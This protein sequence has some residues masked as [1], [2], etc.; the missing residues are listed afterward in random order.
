MTNHPILHLWE[1]KLQLSGFNLT[2]FDSHY[3]YTTQKNRMEPSGF[4]FRD[5]PRHDQEKNRQRICRKRNIIQ[6]ITLVEMELCWT[7]FDRPSA[8]FFI[9]GWKEVV[10]Y[11][12]HWHPSAED[13]KGVPCGTGTAD[14]HNHFSNPAK[15]HSRLCGERFAIRRNGYPFAGSDAKRRPGIKRRTEKGECFMNNSLTQ[16]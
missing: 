14:G 2:S 5:D 3:K 13:R 1:L 10:F 7:K 8:V 12:D 11:D 15:T 4:V 6:S 9:K 16:M